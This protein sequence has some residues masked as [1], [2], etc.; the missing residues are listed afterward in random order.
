MHRFKNRA[1]PAMLIIHNQGGTVFF[2]IQK[3]A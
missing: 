3:G 1:V 2:S